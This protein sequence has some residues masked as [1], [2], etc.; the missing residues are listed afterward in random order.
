MRE[1]RKQRSH[2]DSYQGNPAT[3]LVSYRLL[4]SKMGQLSLSSFQ[5]CSWSIR[6]AFEQRGKQDKTA[7]NDTR[8]E[9]RLIR[10]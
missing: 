1:I 3:L 10:V 6:N 5:D 2:R 8:D 7:L 9:D 4:F